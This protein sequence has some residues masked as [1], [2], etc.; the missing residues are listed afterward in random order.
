MIRKTH[1]Q[2]TKHRGPTCKGGREGAA[3][4][5]EHITANFAEFAVS[6]QQCERCRASKLFAFLQRR[7]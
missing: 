3:L 7:A 2:D 6:T 1:L 5:G 4:S